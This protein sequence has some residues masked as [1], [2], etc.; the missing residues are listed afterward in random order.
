MKTNQAILA[1]AFSVLMLEAYTGCKSNAAS[2]DASNASVN[3]SDAPVYRAVTNADGIGFYT[4]LSISVDDKGSVTAT[5]TGCGIGAGIHPIEIACEA[6][7]G[8]VSTKEF[9]VL[10]FEESQEPDRHVLLA[11]EAQIGQM[12]ALVREK[13]QDHSHA[14]GPIYH[15]GSTFIANGSSSTITILY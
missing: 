2:E 8:G 13:N 6:R 1:V 5:I 11:T 14:E 9:G 7:D 15:S 3:A 12:K 10:K 4:N